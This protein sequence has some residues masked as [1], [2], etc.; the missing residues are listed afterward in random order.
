MMKP[1]ILLI[2][3]DQNLT[4][5]I[6]YNLIQENFAVYCESD[7]EEGLYAT[8]EIVPDLILLDWMLPNLSGIEICRRIRR[9]KKTRNVPVIMLTARAEESDRIRGLNTGADDYVTKPFSP[10]ELIAR[11]KAVLRRIRPALT[12]GTLSFEDI[13]LDTASHRVSRC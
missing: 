11:I 6:R 12:E 2:E 1:K 9:N 3:D 5:L 7:G 8:E 13:M 10:K 4:E